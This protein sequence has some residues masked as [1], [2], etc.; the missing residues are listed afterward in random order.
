MFVYA[1]DGL[2]V[3]LQEVKVLYLSVG[4]RYSVMIRLDQT[5]GNYSLRFA[6]Y[7]TGDMQQVL[8]GQAIVS[9]SNSAAMG[10]SM[11]VQNDPASAWMLTNGSATAS[12]A[13]L[14]PSL[15]S[16]FDGNAPPNTAADLTKLFAISQTG[17]VTWVVDSYPYAES[18]TPILFGNSSDGWQANT[19]VHLP[20]NST[21][22]IIMTVANDSMDTM[23]HPMHLHGHKFWIL[24]SGNGSFP[25][26][27]IADAPQSLIN[28]RNPP[29]RDTTDLPVSG[30][31]AIRYVTDNP[32]AWLL[33]C[34]IQWHLVSGMALVLVEGED[35][36]PSIL[37]ASNVSTTAT[38]SSTSSPTKSAS[39][40]RVS[41]DVHL[42]ATVAFIALFVTMS[43]VS[44]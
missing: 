43:I 31:V 26:N 27:S 10:T 38:S 4:Q 37:N 13:T 19:T 25:Y 8:E 44:P 30:W 2:F 3:E 7:P 23:G 35:K 24:G 33:H 32:G 15:L 29:Y 12:T 21:I 18:T 42:G 39:A 11:G 5:P 20:F 6:T 17:I 14:D 28:L 22:D 36:I 9:Y 40:S 41:S 16:P 1:A 34:H